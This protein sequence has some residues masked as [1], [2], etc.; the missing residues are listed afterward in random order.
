MVSLSVVTR[1]AETQSVVILTSLASAQEGTHRPGIV[2][3]SMV[4]MS[5]TMVVTFR[6]AGVPVG[7]FPSILFLIIY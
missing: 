5:S 2:V 7:Y 1:T 6:T 3:M 4:A